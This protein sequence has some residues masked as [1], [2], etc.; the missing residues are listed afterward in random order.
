METLRIEDYTVEALP[1]VAERLL[2]CFA[3]ERFFAFYGPMGVGK[4]TLIKS[5]C[6]LL[7][8][9]DNVCSPTFAIVNEYTAADRSPVYHFDFYRLK[10]VEEAYD[11]GCEEYFESDAHCFLEWPELVESLMPERYVRV[12]LSE[13]DGKRRLSA[14]TVI[15]R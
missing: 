7:G 3:D 4:T 11:I 12:I 8:V 6:T 10:R 9:V 13:N 2:S 15:N 14:E 1:Q 5:C